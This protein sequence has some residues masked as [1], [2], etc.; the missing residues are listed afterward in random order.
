MMWTEMLLLFVIGIFGGFISG[1][2]GIGG[3]III[4]PALL[5]IPPLLG[6]PVMTAYV[7]SGLTSAQ[8]FFSTLSGAFSARKKDAF[9]LQLVLYMGGGMLI[10]S[11]LGA[12][13]AHLIN[14][15]FVTYVYIGVAI[16]ALVL[17]FFKVTPRHE[18][19]RFHRLLLVL[20]GGSVGIVSGIV[21]AG[22][23][24]II[25]PILLAVF[26]LP[27]NTVVANSIVIAFISSI[28]TFVTKAFQGYIPLNLACAIV[29]G[30][31][32]FAPIGL[33]VGRHIPS[34]VQKGIISLLIILA[35][36]QL[37]F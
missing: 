22:G 13:V 17:L 36:T 12:I 29:L 5:L 28:G 37:I 6:Y 1:L 14:A 34:T 30:S 8:V 31:I 10:G 32:I 11:S 19:P 16:L 7:A 18:T 15:D 4:Y 2:V 9:S 24:F 3:A 26:K 35:I 20:I 33:H 25:T 27:M 23:A 21:G